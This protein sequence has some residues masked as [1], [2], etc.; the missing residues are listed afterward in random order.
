MDA[1]RIYSSG[2]KNVCATMGTALTNY[3]INLIK[4]LKCKVILNMDS[5]SAGIKAALQNG[6]LLNKNGIEVN[7]LKLSNAKDPDEYKIKNGVDSYKDS[8]NHA[9]S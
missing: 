2:I 7:I 4:K 3:H 9:I 8:L 6:E 1:I 5:D